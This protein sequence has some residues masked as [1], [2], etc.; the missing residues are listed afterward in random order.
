[1]NEQT[2]SR[3]RPQAQGRTSQ[4]K[5]RGYGRNNVYAKLRQDILSLQLEPGV[6]LDEQ[7][8]AETYG[9]SRTPMR[10][11]LFRLAGEGLVQMRKNSPTR[12]TPMDI[13]SLREH[14]EAIETIHR[15]VARWATARRTDEDMERI[16]AC[17]VKFEEAARSGDWVQMLAANVEFHGAIGLAAKN[18]YIYEQYLRLLNEGQRYAQT[19]FASPF[20]MAAEREENWRRVANDHR[21]IIAALRTRNAEEADRLSLQHA[22]N[23]HVRLIKFLSVSGAGE[24]PL[25][26]K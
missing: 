11:A 26:T 20:I 1:M 14:R 12:V 8:L 5:A 22:E 16:E 21:A 19:S 4:K 13:N 18:R 25:G 24:V 17:Q 9:V 3:A 6:L 10:E 7:K 2:Q 15:V 23:G